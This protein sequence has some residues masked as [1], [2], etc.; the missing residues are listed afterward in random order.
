MTGPLLFL[1]YWL[2]FMIA[3]RS[4]LFQD[5][6]T[7]WHTRIGD[8]ILA[9]GFFRSDP[10]TYTH[11]GQFWIPHQWLGE[12]A[13]ACAH[14]LGGLDSF[15]LFTATLLAGLFT[16]L[17]LRLLRTGLHISLCVL[18]IAIVI[19][20]TATHC[21]V[22]P[23]LFTT[24]AM[25]ITAALLTDYDEGRASIRSLLW[26]VPLTLVWANI[27]GGLLGGLASMG[28]VGVGW[29]VWKLLG[30]P[31]PIQSW[32]VLGHL[33]GIA[34]IS[35]AMMFVTPYGAEIPRTWLRIMSGSK[36]AE[37]IEEHQPL[38]PAEP[39]TW[40]ALLLA[41]IYI[42]IL[43]GTVPSRPRVV[44]L[45]PLFWFAQ[46]LLRVRHAP[47]FAM[48]ACIA[49]TSIWPQTRWAQSLRNRPDLYD[50]TR[51][52]PMS[53]TAWLL[54]LCVIATCLH[55]QI[56]GIHAPLLGTGWARPDPRHWPVEL[57]DVIRSH[58]PGPDDQAN[59]FTEL[60]LGG[61]LSFHAPGY[62]TFIDD[63]AELYGD[64]FLED[65]IRGAS[66]AEAAIPA[67]QAKYGTM[68]FA[69]VRPNTSFDHYF[70]THD[71]ILLASCDAANFYK[72]R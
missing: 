68:Q 37:Y 7:F 62:K 48:T 57:L 64:Q 21:H 8:L 66:N 39:G 24:V 46:M 53:R 13:M 2:L 32:R 12:I 29:V 30:W 58:E 54:P 5:P 1:G 47:I 50:P 10:F 36:I 67:W 22:R 26:L 4:R 59:T 45:L 33:I 17:T 41:G 25:A 51:R 72:H 42:V 56:K 55:L 18:F 71:W 43:A 14:R 6:G 23:I 65:Y 15:L 61:F 35:A 11:A 31:S 70:R 38:N 44:W 9:Q 19:S 34:A 52:V 60:H 20:A 40:G 27:H 3:G 28:L 69:L 16:W 49:I 63:R